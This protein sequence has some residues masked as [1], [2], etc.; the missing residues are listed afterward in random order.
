MSNIKPKYFDEDVKSMNGDVTQHRP[1]GSFKKPYPPPPVPSR[2]N[3]VYKPTQLDLPSTLSDQSSSSSSFGQQAISECRKRKAFSAAA[4]TAAE[5]AS[6]LNSIESIPSVLGP[7]ATA[8]TGPSMRA[9]STSFVSLANAPSHV[10][11]VASKKPLLCSSLN[12]LN[13]IAGEIKS[14]MNKKIISTNLTNVSRK[15]GI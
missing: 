1:C 3:A 14:G 6:S 13:A 7:T 10:A 9:S 5:A 15:E 11:L 2:S 12:E 4:T 8:T